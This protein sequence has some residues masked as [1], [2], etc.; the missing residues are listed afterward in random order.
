[1][2]GGVMMY[3]YSLREELVQLPYNELLLEPSI[4]L[5]LSP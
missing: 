1:M 4:I 2:Y 5:N 3:E